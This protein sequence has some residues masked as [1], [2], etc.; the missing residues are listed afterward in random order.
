[1][2]E[3]GH[4]IVGVD[5]PRSPRLTPLRIPESVRRRLEV[6]T[7]MAWEALVE[8]HVNQATL[9]VQ[10]LSERIPLEEALVRYLLELDLSEAM[11]S[12]VRTRVL[13]AVEPD[14]GRGE[15]SEAPIDEDPEGWRRFRPDVVMRGVVARQRRNDETEQWVQLAVARA[16]EAVITTHVDNAITFAALLE[17]VLPL[18]R[19]V[20]QYL[21]AVVLSGGRAQAV[22]QRTMARLADVHLPLP[23]ARRRR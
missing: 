14:A 16:E 17:D 9:F 22:F 21:G 4:G 1:M 19:A 15:T 5:M 13:V 2:H 23:T 8:T 18:G 20:Q 3:R 11:A 7:A 10:V 12:A 6:A